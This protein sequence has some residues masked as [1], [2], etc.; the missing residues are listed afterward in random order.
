MSTKTLFDKLY[1]VSKEAL[2]AAK[3]PFAENRLKLGI[4]SA[5]NNADLAIVEANDKFE[6]SLLDVINANGDTNAAILA[7]TKAIAG[8]RVAEQVKADLT[9]LE[10]KIFGAAE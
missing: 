7:A 6:K 5:I 8:V 1:A 10:G 9:A 4:K 3:K 2:D